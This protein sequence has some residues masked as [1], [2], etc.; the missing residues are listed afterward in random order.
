MESGRLI[1]HRGAEIV[2]REQLVNYP[3]PA[4]FKPVGYAELQK[5]A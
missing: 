2:T 5:D 3:A 1:A 4:T